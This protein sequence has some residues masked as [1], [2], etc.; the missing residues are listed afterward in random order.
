M[1]TRTIYKDIPGY[2]GVYRVSN[3]G[4]VISNNMRMHTRK[5][6]REMAINYIEGLPTVRL[7]KPDGTFK[8]VGVHRLVAQL[9][10]PNDDPYKKKFV[11][12]IN[13]DKT[14]NRAENLEWFKPVITFSDEQKRM[15]AKH[16]KENIRPK[17]MAVIM[18]PVK[19][20]D[21]KTGELLGKYKSLSEAVRTYNLKNHTHEVYGVLKGIYKQTMGYRLEYVKKYHKVNDYSLDIV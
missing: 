12:H 4:K 5:T 17:A 6:N 19:V 3:K 9:F 18:R 8:Q 21:Y 10:V 11:R 16:M 13:G 7:Y 14:D 15:Y 2:D 20:Y 1:A